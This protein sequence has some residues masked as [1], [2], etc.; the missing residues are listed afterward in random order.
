M[1]SASEVF[2]TIRLTRRKVQ[3]ARDAVRNHAPGPRR[4]EAVLR[5]A[6]LTEELLC[7]IQK[8]A[9]LGFEEDVARLLQNSEPPPSSQQRELH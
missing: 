4:D 5:A 1:P 8:F 6:I 3:I 7:A 2:D 9:Q